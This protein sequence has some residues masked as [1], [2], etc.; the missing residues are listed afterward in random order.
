VDGT[1]QAQTGT[2]NP[3]MKFFKEM[4]AAEAQPLLK[5]V[6]I[7][8]ELHAYIMRVLDAV[9][10]A[11]QVPVPADF[12]LSLP[13]LKKSIKKVARSLN[14][15]VRF[16]PTVGGGFMVR[17]ATVDEMVQGDRQGERLGER[18]RKH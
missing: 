8:G 7:D 3:Y 12:P 9:Q 10:N 15:P 1:E 17:Q 2:T 11:K 14:I 5:R 4:S 6:R 16:D 13:A 18:R